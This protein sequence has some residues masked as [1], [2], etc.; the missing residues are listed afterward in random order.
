[1]RKQLRAADLYQS[2]VGIERLPQIKGV[3]SYGM[4]TSLRISRTDFRW[5]VEVTFSDGVT[6]AKDVINTADVKMFIKQVNTVLRDIQTLQGGK[7]V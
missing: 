1:M 3:A 4:H 5:R 7:R 2:F 6:L